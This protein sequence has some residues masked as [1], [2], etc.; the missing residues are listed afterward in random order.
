MGRKIDRKYSVYNTMQA[1]LRRAGFEKSGVLTTLLLETFLEYD[2]IL[3]AKRVEDLGLCESEGF[4]AWREPLIKAGWLQYDHE[5]AKATKKGSLHQPGR[6][7]VRYV[8][9]ER[10]N[11]Q[12]LASKRYVDKR[13]EQTDE[14][15][16]ALENL[17]DVIIEAFDP[18][19]NEE[20]R[21]KYS[22]DPDGLLRL[23]NSGK[24]KAAVG[25][26]G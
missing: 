1:A 18:P 21:K 26:Q 19:G 15:L 12:E 9:K 25:D 13:V 20:K 16:T 11:T 24:R 7:L 14:R 17:V 3:T 10:A 4:K 23:I 5:F 8:N 2:G 22:K 6:K